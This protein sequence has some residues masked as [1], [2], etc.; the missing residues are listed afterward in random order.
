MAKKKLTVNL[1]EEVVDIL[2]QLSERNG[3]TMTEEIRKSIAD[4]KY[5]ADK[6]D[7]GSDVILEQ[8]SADRTT[9]SRISV[10]LR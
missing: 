3:S 2:G 4:R 6:I 1:S 9:V 8:P 5:F 10:D 7:A